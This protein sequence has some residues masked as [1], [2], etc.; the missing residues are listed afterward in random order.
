MV[1]SSL[2]CPG[3]GVPQFGGSRRPSL[4]GIMASTSSGFGVPWGPG[5]VFLRGEVPHFGGAPSFGVSQF[6]GAPVWAVPR[7]PAILVLGC[8]GVQVIFLGVPQFRGL[9]SFRVSLVLG[10][11]IFHL[12]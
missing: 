4:G 3:F 1:C 7:V 11:P 5:R 10:Y 2:G 12:A 6:G 8:F 9:P